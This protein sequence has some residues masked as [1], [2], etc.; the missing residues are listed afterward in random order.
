MRKLMFAFMCTLTS[1]LLILG[2]QQEQK[3]AKHEATISKYEKDLV[4]YENYMSTYL[5]DIYLPRKQIEAEGLAEE[6]KLK[7][8]QQFNREYPNKEVLRNELQNVLSG[9]VESSKAM[10]IIGNIIEGVTLNNIEGNA[11]DNNDIIITIRDPKIGQYVIAIDMSLNCA[12]DKR[13][14]LMEIEKAQQF[15]KKLFETAFN[16]YTIRGYKHTFWSFLE[17]SKEYLWYEEIK[18]ME[19]TN[20]EYLKELHKKYKY[21]KEFLRSFEFLVSTR[22]YEN[23]DFFGNKVIRN[24]NKTGEDVTIVITSGFNILDQF[25]KDNLESSLNAEYKT[26]KDKIDTE[27]EQFVIYRLQTHI[28]MLLCSLIFGMLFVYVIDT[29]K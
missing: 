10:D 6:I 18:N 25:Q 4:N 28:F 20:I 11:K 2:F 1:V 8:I 5:L 17:P 24:G 14:R 26:L 9:K 21:N 16:D 12:T 22:I 15:A 3:K 29:K 27:N 19:S 13:I 7:I 23:E